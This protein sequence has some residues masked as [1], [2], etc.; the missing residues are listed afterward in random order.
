[1]LTCYDLLIEPNQIRFHFVL[2]LIKRKSNET[3]LELWKKKLY[4][5]YSLLGF[6]PVAKGKNAHINSQLEFARGHPDFEVKYRNFLS[7]ICIKNSK[8]F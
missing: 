6:S 8:M 4:K 5:L 7:I 3:L 2:T 1:M